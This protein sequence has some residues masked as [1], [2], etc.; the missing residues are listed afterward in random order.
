MAKDEVLSRCFR[1]NITNPQH[2]KVAK[3]LKNLN[4]DIYK[5]QNQFIVDALE[6]YIDNYGSDSFVVSEDDGKG[7]YVKREEFEL[8]GELLNAKAIEAA[9]DEVSKIWGAVMVDLVA[10]LAKNDGNLLNQQIQ[11]SQYSKEQQEM[12]VET[13]ETLNEL[14]SEWDGL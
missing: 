3:V 5:S 14:I 4:P 12:D 10:S 7:K 6:F 8:L 1:L 9:K 13:E 11:Q 2:M